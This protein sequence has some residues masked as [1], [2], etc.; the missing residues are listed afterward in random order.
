MNA[1]AIQPRTRQQWADA[2]NTEWRKSIEGIIRTGEMLEQAA[3]GLRGEYAKM[4]TSDLPFTLAT[5]D[6]L[7]RIARHPAIRDS[8]E[9]TSLPS[10]WTVLSELAGLSADD[11]RDA[12]SKGLIG[13]ATVTKQARAVAGAYRTP[14]GGVVGN[15]DAPK[16]TLPS[17]SDARRIARDTGRLVAAADGRLYTGASEEEA[18]DSQRRRTQT[19]QVRDAIELLADFDA[20]PALWLQEADD[21]LLYKFRIGCISAAIDWLRE[22]EPLIAERLGVHDA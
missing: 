3:H 13:P 16:H 7:R 21:H 5:A 22:L 2:I 1:P 15:V 4:V 17:P 8:S 6:K 12:Q 9:P 14:E 10:S 18:A 19:L 11:F 20:D